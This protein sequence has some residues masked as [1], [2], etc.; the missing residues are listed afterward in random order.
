MGTSYLELADG[1]IVEIGSP[2]EKRKE[3][4]SG[5]LE[6]VDSTFEMVGNIVEKIARPIGESF[7]NMQ[8]AL[9]IPIEVEKAE[10]ELGISFAAEGTIFVAKSKAEGSLNIKII[11]RPV[12]SAVNKG[13]VHEDPTIKGAREKL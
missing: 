8:T 7:R 11:F 10:I 5:D 12:K 3:M 1:I 6:R 4:H 9:A 13:A 2:G